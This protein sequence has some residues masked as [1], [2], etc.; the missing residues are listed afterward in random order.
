MFE[1]FT[2]KARNIIILARKEAEK[3]NHDFLGTE[4]ILL[5]IL[6]QNDEFPIL[7]LRKLGIDPERVR[8]DIEAAIPK[9]TNTLTYDEIPFTSKARRALELA[10]DEARLLKHNYI[11]SEH[12]LLGLIRE[13][14][15]IAGNILR[16]L[17]ANIFGAR[18]LTINILQRN[19]VK[20]APQKTKSETPT[21]DEFGRDLTELARENKLDPVIGRDTEIERLLQILSRRTKNNPV[22]IGEPGVGKTAIVEGLSQRIANNEVPEGLNNRRVVSLDLGSIVAGTKYR[23]QFEERLKTIVKE[24]T[25][26]QGRIITFIDE[27]HTLIGA[28]AAEGSLDASNMLKPALSRGELQCIGATTPAEYRKTIEKDGALDRRFQP[29]EVPPA[30]ID[31]SIQIIEGLKPRYEEHHF[32]N[33]TSEA[34]EAAVKLSDRYITNKYLPDKAIDVIDE[35]GSRAKLQKYI[36]PDSLKA[37]EQEIEEV[38]KEK[39]VYIKLQEFEKAAKLRDR[40]ERLIE[41]YDQ[42]KDEWREQQNKSKVSITVE[43]VEYIVSKMT[44]IPLVRLEETETAKL[45]RMEVELHKRVIGQDTAISAVSRAIRRSR[46]GLKHRRRPIGSFLFLGPTGVGKT[47]LARSLAKVLF[48]DENAMIRVDMSEF[49]EKFTVSAL[50]GA[51]PGYV[52]YEEGGQLTEKVRRRPY[53][54]V[55][56]D[57][58]EKAHPDIFNILLQVLDDGHLTDNYGRVVDFSNTVLIM[59]SNLG[60]R[61]IERDSTVGFGRE[62]GILSMDKISGNVMEAVKDRFNPEFLNRLDEAV[63]FHP[64]EKVH[65]RDIVSLLIGDLNKDLA[66]RELVVAANDAALDWLIDRGYD[67]KFGARPLR[68]T[69]QKYLE[70][71]LSEMIL[72]GTVAPNTLVRIDLDPQTDQLTFTN[73]PRPAGEAVVETSATEEEVATGAETGA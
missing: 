31:E 35:A 12:I 14:E 7:I 49:M 24:I 29:I 10:V 1:R 65:L 15:G 13:E 72:R 66:E 59:T 9:G 34:I 44:G 48:D 67:P 3:F 21:L 23:G 69:I 36:I 50:T 40:E 18:Q 73:E 8:Q 61:S 5:G 63:V 22:L 19:L 57:E 54:V 60:T 71:Q 62:E 32:A 47:E 55:L 26:S 70:D 30:S 17:G 37:K 46:A 53:S 41:E 64:L 52:G 20:N 33:I 2:D 68:R 56:L 11:G 25:S 51:P 4:H 45:L 28:G 27:L 42:A 6:A 43:N 39:E 16:S 58:I 38:I